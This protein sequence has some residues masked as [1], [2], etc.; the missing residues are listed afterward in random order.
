MKKAIVSVINDLTTDQ[1][2]HRHCLC[3]ADHNY[4]VQLVGRSLRTS[5][6]VDN[7]EYSTLRFKLPFETGPL[8]YAS[9]NIRLFIHLLFTKADLLFSNDLDTLLPNYL[10]S[11]LKRIDLIYDSHELFSEVPEVQARPM[12]K[13]FWKWLER[14]LLPKVSY[15]MTVNGSIAETYMKWYGVDMKVHRNLPMKRVASITVSRSQL[16]LPT[17][18][19]IIVLQGAG[20]NVDRGAEEAVQAMQYLNDHVLLIIG[21]GDVINKLK[22]M[23]ADLQLEEKVKILG[24]MPYTEMMEYTACADLGLSL[25]KDTNLNYRLS[26]PNKL[27]DYLQAGTPVLV[28]QLPELAKVVIENGVGELLKGHDPKELAHQI[29]TMLGNSEKMNEFRQNC[30]KASKELVWENERKVLD[31]MI[32]Q[33]N[34]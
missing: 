10:V 6:L 14:T 33:I 32:K 20:I 17:T 21:S 27:F 7:R 26:L 29:Q 8:F 3:L 1:R 22:L 18:K 9:Y 5:K 28:S 34:G 23:V 25:D 2:V 31:N 24:R 4:Q 16:D 13:A 11:R 19:K 15:L 30:K 12:V